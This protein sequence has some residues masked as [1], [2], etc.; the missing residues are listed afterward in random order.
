LAGSDVLLPAPRHA[1]G[2][3]RWSVSAWLLARRDRGGPT[4]APGGMLGGS[5]AGARV[6]YRLGGGLS[7]GALFHAPLRRTGGA[8]IAAGLDWQPV[9][10]IPIH[11]RAERRQALGRSG[12]S[13]FA[14]SVHGGLSRRLPRRLRLDLY[15]QA[16][17]VGA[18]ARDLFADGAARL[19]APLGP[20]EISAGAWGAA[21]PG[22]ARLDA[23][24]G[25]SYRLPVRGANVRIEAGWRF[26]LAGDAMPRSGPALTLGA[27]F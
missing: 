2:A 12:R 24:P 9:A 11:V 19:S 7:V 4:L 10:A 21:Q 5:Q 3:G 1:R 17:A 6:G 22:A 15:G 26:R 25:I 16:G 8:E 14:L 18:R 13:A 27:D 20:V 23:G